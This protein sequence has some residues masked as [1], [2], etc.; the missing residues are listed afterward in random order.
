MRQDHQ[1]GIGQAGLFRGHSGFLARCAISCC[2]CSHGGGFRLSRRPRASH[3]AWGP[4]RGA[5][6]PDYWVT[7]GGQSAAGSLLDY[8]ISTFGGE[9]S[10]DAESHR[11]VIDRIAVLRRI[12]GAAFG[13]GIH[14]LPDIHGNR[15]PFADPHARGVFSGLTLDCS[16]D[17]LCR[18]YWRTAVSLA[19]GVRHIVE[20]LNDD[21]SRIGALHIAGG[22]RN[23]PVLMDIYA[24]ATGLSLCEPETDDAVLLGSAMAAAT[25]AGLHESLQAACSAMRSPV[26]IHAPDPAAASGFERDYR[27]FLTMHDQK[28]ALDRL[29]R[30]CPDD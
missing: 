11:R 18:V 27:I 10:P 20:R 12:E 13:A 21:G 9:A 5:V 23:N 25:A 1:L 4:F 29:M 17:N 24:S 22:H 26:R 30:A 14:V 3:G 6:L 8:V 19:L 15:A 7:E 2:I 16:F 28:Q